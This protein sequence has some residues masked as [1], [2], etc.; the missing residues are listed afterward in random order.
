M[1]NNACGTLPDY[2]WT[3]TAQKEGAMKDQLRSVR[4]LTRSIY[5]AIAGKI[6]LALRG[7]SP[8]SN[9]C[10]IPDV[11]QKYRALGLPERQGIFVEVGAFD[12][13]SFSNTSF[14]ADQGWRGV[15]IEPVRRFYRWMRLR[16]ILN[17]VVGE[18]V[19]IAEN[20]GTAE[21]SVMGAL[22]T[23]NA[24]TAQH[25]KSVWWAKAS[26]DRA[27]KVT[28]C[29]EPLGVVFKRNNIPS[30]FDLMVV[31][32]EGGEEQIVQEMMG[33]PWRPR[34]LIIELCDVH[35]D[36]ASNEELTGSHARV[37]SSV[38]GAGYSEYYVDPINTI[39][40]LADSSP[41]AVRLKVG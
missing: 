2:F 9:S 12:G 4:Y 35:A 40:V 21:I 36:F 34:V 8:V 38:L 27:K 13:E 23:M 17:N 11:R 19:A 18:N 3:S 25:Y 10:Q 6:A 1:A 31:D 22:S 16:H 28:I 24:A 39:F 26:V 30:R 5:K 29:T 33:G 37:R 7:E 20:S 14:L 32:V 41:V 15:Y